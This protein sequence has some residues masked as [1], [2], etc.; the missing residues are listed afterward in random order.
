MSNLKDIKEGGGSVGST[1]TNTNEPLRILRVATDL[2][3]EV[4]GG[5]ALH[6]HRMSILQSEMGHDVTVL[7][8]DH[9]DRSLPR[10][11]F[12]GGYTLRRF[13]EVGRPFENSFTPGMIPALNRLARKFDI[14]HAHSHLYFSTNITAAQTYLA[15]IPFVV[16]NHGLYSQSAPDW[17]Q[18]ILSRT[19]WRLT[20]NAADRVFCYTNTD[21]DRLEDLGVDAPVSVISNGIN[22]KTFQPTEAE[23]QSDILYVGRL[24]EAKGVH[25]LLE[26]FAGLADEFPEVTLTYV[27]TGPLETRLQ[28]QA[29]ALG[30]AERVKL[31][32]HVENGDLPEIYSKSQLFVLPSKAEGLPRTVLEALACETPVVTSNL[33]QLEPLVNDVGLTVPIGSVESLRKAIR[34]LLFDESQRVRMG[35]KGRERVV[36]NY[37]WTETVRETTGEYYD[38]LSDYG[39]RSNGESDDIMKHSVGRSII[40]ML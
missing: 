23:R 36:D 4:L 2:Y 10:T 3:P 25:W 15:D 26:A 13:R 6:A 27:G 29:A 8:S 17:I 12:R 30:V 38:I 37:S 21:R 35:T 31:H 32:G 14:V 24:K 16:T 40:D 22:C 19:L 11:E 5:G 33:P 39:R 28:E 1:I 9:G 7:T 34:T 18:S 20:F